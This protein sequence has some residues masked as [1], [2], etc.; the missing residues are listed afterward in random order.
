MSN[1]IW[2][3]E[4]VTWTDIINPTED[5]LNQFSK[6][7]HI[8]HHVLADCLEPNHLPKIEQLNDITFILL[9]LYDKKVNKYPSSV[10][11][12]SNKI[13]MFYNN[14]HLIT[15]HRNP[16]P[17]IKEIKTKYFDTGLT[18][19]TSQI[20]IKLM[21]YIVQTYEAAS[22][23]LSEDIDIME[24]QIFLGKQSKITLE[25]LY[26]LKNSCRLNKKLMSLTNDVINHYNS[27]ES[28]RSAL[29]DVK[30]FIQKLTHSFEETYEDSAN[31]S[32]TYLSIMSKKTN[33]A[34]KLLTIFSVFFMPLTFI[35]GI[36]G[37]NF[38]YMPELRWKIG[39]PLILFI[40]FAISAIIFIW[41]KRKKIL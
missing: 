10:Q 36:Y 11:E 18:K 38:L 21:W 13:A 35:V 33:D 24:K 27:S 39:Y 40:M 12:M 26:Y 19:E 30:D 22:V 1:K 5:E 23:K 17:L 25:D 20:V 15:I 34:I 4:Q 8:N 7:H 37:M 16:H 9:R 32:R 14:K 3:N 41:F 6:Q 29:Q 31:L 2:N 28:D